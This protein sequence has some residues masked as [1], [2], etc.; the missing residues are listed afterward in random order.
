MWLLL[1]YVDAAGIIAVDVVAEVTDAVVVYVA[2]AAAFTNVVVVTGCGCGC[3]RWWCRCCMVL[4]L[5]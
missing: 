1:M 3:K 4:W 5:Y 2:V